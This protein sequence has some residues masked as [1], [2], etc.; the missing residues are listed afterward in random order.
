MDEQPQQTA[1][2]RGRTRHDATRSYHDDALRA[3]EHGYVPIAEAWARALGQEVLT[4]TFAQAP[5]EVAAVRQQILAAGLVRSA[6]M[7]GGKRPVGVPAPVWGAVQ[8]PQPRKGWSRRRWVAIGVAVL[9]ILGGA[10]SVARQGDPSAR[11]GLPPQSTA[12]P[13]AQPT[14]AQT[15]PP[16]AT[17]VPPT[18]TP[19]PA[20]G[21]APTGFT[22]TA[23]VVRVVD[24][25]T[26]IVDRGHGEERLRYIGVDT[27][28]TVAP[29]SPVEWMGA[30][31]TAANKA[32]VE[33]QS[34]V[35]EKDV[36]ETD[37]YDR[38]LRYVWLNDGASWTLVNA[39]LLSLGVAQVVTYPPDVKYADI[40]LERQKEARDAGIGLWGPAP[41]PEPTARPTPKPTAQP[42][43]KPTKK[44]SSGNC[45]PS[46]PDF[47]VPPYPPDLNCN[48]VYAQGWSDITVLPPDPHG[49]D[50]NDNDGIGCESP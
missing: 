26:I 2:Y 17:L 13:T 1:I 28:E 4:V 50:G 49:F 42:T 43:P 10:G 44:P 25:D 40:Y 48:W 21:A 11:V 27:P 8:A 32:L 37:Q 14:I 31:A 46:Y 5:A 33:G 15:A 41:T 34:V 35:L 29:G 45:D 20:L 6:D 3:A 12:Q 9:F 22:E 36:S 7:A 30:E 16:I 24:G 39:Q 47:C 23:T 19:E 38:L 18:A